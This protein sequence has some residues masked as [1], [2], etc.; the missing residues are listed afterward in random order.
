MQ[1]KY[2]S[3]VKSNL[4]ALYKNKNFARTF[5]KMQLSLNFIF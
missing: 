3:S 1:K 4:A 2:I 5:F